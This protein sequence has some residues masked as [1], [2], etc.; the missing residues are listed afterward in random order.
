MSWIEE[1]RNR[2]MREEWEAAANPEHKFHAAYE[3]A[4][5]VADEKDQI[6]LFQRI[7]RLPL[8]MK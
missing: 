1:K 8:E 3:I 2:K 5:Q 4:K 6:R 7:K